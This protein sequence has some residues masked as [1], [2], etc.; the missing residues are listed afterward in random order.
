MH[1]AYNAAEEPATPDAELARFYRLC[2]QATRW[3]ETAL[4]KVGL[5]S[6]ASVVG[7]GRGWGR[8]GAAMAEQTLR[9]ALFV[10]GEEPYAGAPDQAPIQAARKT[11]L[12]TVKAL[13]V[14]SRVADPR[15]ER[16]TLRTGTAA[17]SRAFIAAWPFFGDAPNE[18]RTTTAAMRAPS[19]P[20]T[21]SPVSR[22]DAAS[23][24]PNLAPRGF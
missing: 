24:P 7:Q 9:T 14:A 20:S 19:S 2:D 6:Y 21:S 8:D 12:E 1:A 4:R 16:R 10:L 5:R 23:D 15:A 22:T 18:A 11:I 3:C 13:G 17:V